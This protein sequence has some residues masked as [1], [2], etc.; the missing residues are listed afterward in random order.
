[1]AC[2]RHAAANR[3]ECDAST[4]SD[5][6]MRCALDDAVGVFTAGRKRWCHRRRWSMGAPCRSSSLPVWRQTQPDADGFGAFGPGACTGALDRLQTQ[7]FSTARVVVLLTTTPP[8]LTTAP[9]KGNA[10]WRACRCH[11]QHFRTTAGRGA[12]GSRILLCHFRA[13]SAAARTSQSIAPR[14]PPNWADVSRRYGKSVSDS[15]SRVAS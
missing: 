8:P 15:Y 3:L 5:L 4:W 6:V 7:H 12:S 13:G 2:C 1:M 10:V 14:S 9:R 11:P